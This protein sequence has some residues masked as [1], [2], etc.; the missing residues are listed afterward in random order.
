MS[1][2]ALP[3]LLAAVQLN[4]D[5]TDARFAADLPL[6]IYLLQMRE[7]YR[8]EQ[9]LAFGDE[10]PRAALGDWLARREAHWDRL[11]GRTLEPVPCGGVLVDPFDVLTIHAAL[12]P[13]GLGYGAGL[14]GPGRP[15]F[16]VAEHDAPGPVQVDGEPVR[17]RLFGRELARSLASPL[18]LLASLPE[19]DTIVLRQAAL[20]RWL[21]ERFEVHS[22]RPAEGAFGRFAAACGVQTA[23]AFN[24]GLPALLDTARPVLLL[25]E[26][27]ELRAG[28]WLGLRWA[29]LRE[30]LADDRRSELRLAAVRDHL[31]DLGTTLP[32]LLAEGAG[33]QLHFWFAGYEGHREA[34][35]PGL[36]PAYAA[37]C[38]GDGG[39]A[40]RRAVL[41]GERHFRH[42]A[43]RLLA[44]PEPGDATLPQALARLLNDAGATCATDPACAG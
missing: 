25:H 17:V 31:A 12:Q 40:L 14:V 15:V 43:A 20:S 8:W 9:G 41:A 26:L 28:R 32:A 18:A 6:C 11:E 27:G 22:L 13:L 24:A 10:L 4:C 19:G 29:G 23:D 37:W 44:L 38:A 5:I 16:F 35:Y 30:A 33:A 36:K 34:L 2:A 21:W 3:P 7:F 39:R 1:P 42:L